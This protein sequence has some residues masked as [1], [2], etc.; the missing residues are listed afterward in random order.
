MKVLSKTVSNLSF[1]KPI[2]AL[3]LFCL[4][5][6]QF[7]SAQIFTDIAED[8]NLDH[9]VENHNTLG[10]GVAFF[11]YDNDMD[12][13]LYLTGGEG[14][15]QLF[16][17][18]GDGTFT[19][20]SFTAGIGL[21]GQ[22]FTAGVI[23]GDIDNDGDRDIYI[24]TGDDLF[25]DPAPNLLLMNNGNGSFSERGQVAGVNASSRSFGATFFDYDLDGYLDLYVVNYVENVNFTRDTLD[26]G[27]PGNVTA[28]AHDCYE[29]V[30][31][32]NNG[33]G[34]F[35][36][37]IL[38][39]GLS[40]IGCGLAVGASD[41]DG[42]DDIDLFVV[43][44]FG[45]FVEPNALFQ[46]QYPQDTFIDVSANTRADV[47]IYGMGIA[48]GDFDQDNDLDYYFTNIGR[49]SLLENQGDQGFLDVADETGTD[50]TWVS[51]PFTRT[52]S[53]GTAFV[54]YNNDTYLDLFVANGEI[55]TFNFNLTGAS[56]P[57]KLYENNGDKTF[58]DISEA[59]GIDNPSRGRGLAYSDYDGDGDID[60]VITVLDIAVMEDFS[61]QTLFYQN[62]AENTN[63]WLQVKLEGVTCNRDAYGSKVRAYVGDKI[64]LFEINGGD[65]HMSQ[66]S[67]VVQ[68]GLGTATQVDSLELDWLG[69]ESEWLYDIEANQRLNLKQGDNSEVEP[70]PIAVTFS[71]DM[72]AVEVSD[73]GVYLAADFE[74]F[75]GSIRL[76]SPNGDGIYTTTQSLLPDTYEYRFVNGLP[77]ASTNYEELMEG[78]SCTVTT[79]GST[80]R[81]LTLTG[82][83]ASLVLDSVCFNNCSAC[84]IE[85]TQQWNIVS[86]LFHLSPTLTQQ[87]SWLTFPAQLNTE[88]TMV[89]M[90]AVGNSIL[91]KT[92][93]KSTLEYEIDSSSMGGGIYFVQVLV[94]DKLQVQRIVV[95][96]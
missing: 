74:D 56:D 91:K 92:L 36:E 29:N 86:D 63:N 83:R 12:D 65:S 79:D 18:N 1:F 54:D 96:R 34:T 13:D 51:Q 48:A 37:K 70:E 64:L 38:A 21:T 9:V 16:R 44:D 10:G 69:G 88:K 49:N 89:I 8:L 17:N 58:T 31:Y 66:S 61:P 85:N 40:D 94:D 84:I 11:D 77:M 24:S 82:E 30:F 25:G 55:E 27:E 90:D 26:N 67:S 19:D 41:Y 80:N 78:D 87:Y 45:E 76:E 39:S 72:R 47:Q 23:T 71:V 59:A 93:D 62:N 95:I 6:L 32:H 46:N 14:R 35:I 33:D 7:L 22:F 75:S 2:T 73:D 52:T 50:N 3:F 53:W 28:Y 68:I 20:V 57:N 60:L 42:D 5:S 15:D 81:I 4:T 43:N